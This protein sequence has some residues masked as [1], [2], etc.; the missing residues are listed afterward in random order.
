[1]E[2]MIDIETLDTKPGGIILEVGVVAFQDG[3]IFSE[4]HS[5]FN[6]VEGEAMGFTASESTLKFWQDQGGIPADLVDA[7]VDNYRVLQALSQYIMYWRNGS[8]M[9]NFTAFWSKGNFDLP[10]LEAYFEAY[11][12]TVPWQYW[13]ARELRTA[14]SELGAPKQENDGDHRALADA[15]DQTAALIE[16][17]R[18]TAITNNVIQLVNQF[19]VI[20]QEFFKFLEEVTT[21]VK[22]Y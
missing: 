15:R 2:F 20:P 22:N 19:D 14:L 6:V 13:E 8:T 9:M 16:A 12:I 17:R 3:R 7:P 18:Y 5:A 10:L 21:F 4:F 1:M 11:N